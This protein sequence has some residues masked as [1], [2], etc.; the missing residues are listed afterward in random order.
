MLLINVKRFGDFA[1]RGVGMRGTWRA[2]L[3]HVACVCAARAEGGEWGFAGL[4]IRL[5]GVVE[6]WRKMSNFA[7]GYIN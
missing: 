2:R 6:M 1:A 7:V 5:C 4:G 3:P